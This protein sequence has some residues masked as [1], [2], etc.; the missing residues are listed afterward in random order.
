MYS[1]IKGTVEDISE[2]LVV[3]ECAG[4]G[5]EISVSTTT[6]SYLRLGAETKL[7]LYQL[8][9]E[10]DISLYGFATAAEKSMFLKLTSVSG[11]GPK[12]ALAVLSGIN[13]SSLTNAIVCGDVKTL[14][15]IKG[16]GKKTAE[17]IVLEL[18]EN[19]DDELLSVGTPVNSTVDAV[20]NNALV[21]LENMGL[22][23][24][25]A[26]EAVLKA[27]AETDNL[28]EII[29]TVLKGLKK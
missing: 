26:Y 1:Y 8:V 14:A 21:A 27:R 22:P 29:R 28:A 4:L 7:F 11:V 18:K 13:V 2:G 5:Y 12:L 9:R 19:V 3:V 16:I 15:K 20:V 24:S 10:D 23:R 17:R 25:Q 6:L